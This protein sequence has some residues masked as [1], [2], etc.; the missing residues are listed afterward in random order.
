[1]SAMEAFMKRHAERYARDEDHQLIGF[2]RQSKSDR[3]M[4][5]RKI[6][7]TLEIDRADQTFER[8][9]VESF[10]TFL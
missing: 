8:A 1:M 4:L 7:V 10:Y 5:D 9:S 6:R 2:L 3:R